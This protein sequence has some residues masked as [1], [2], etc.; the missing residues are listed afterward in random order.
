MFAPEPGW[1]AAA[2]LLPGTGRTVLSIVLFILKSKK[3][4]ADDTGLSVSLFPV[5]S[6]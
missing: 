1:A 5:I 2:A 3:E 4:T 6:F